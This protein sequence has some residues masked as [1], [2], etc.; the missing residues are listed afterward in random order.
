MGS[1]IST[2]YIYE[3]G[4]YFEAEGCRLI[5]DKY[6]RPTTIVPLNDNDVKTFS[7]QTWIIFFVLILPKWVPKSYQIKTYPNY[8]HDT[9]TGTIVHLHDNKPVNFTYSDDNPTAHYGICDQLWVLYV[10]QLT[11][12][13]DVFLAIII[14]IVAVLLSPFVALIYNTYLKAIHCVKNINKLHIIQ[15]T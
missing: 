9:T 13:V 6:N 15:S 10:E 12:T 11:S 14:L 5:L 7:Y 1:T 4:R 2:N 8:L 3:S